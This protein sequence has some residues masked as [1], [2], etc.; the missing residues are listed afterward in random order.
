MQHLFLP[1]KAVLEEVP[2][3][4]S[5]M[6]FILANAHILKSKITVIEKDKGFFCFAVLNIQ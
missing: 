4:S 1:Y 5:S 6:A 3:I 2:S